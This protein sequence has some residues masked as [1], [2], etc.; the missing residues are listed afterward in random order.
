[1]FE[2]VQVV[3]QHTCSL[4]AHLAVVGSP[5]FKYRVVGTVCLS[6][7]L[8]LDG[9]LV[10]VKRIA[11]ACVLRMVS[12]ELPL[13]TTRDW[14]RASVNIIHQYILSQPHLHGDA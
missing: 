12:H 3:I 1:M 11:D 2:G 7:G 6:P 5:P 8:A 9:R 4:S 14:L 13:L 10:R